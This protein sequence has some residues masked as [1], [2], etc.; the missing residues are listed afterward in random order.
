[1][2]VP[3]LQEAWQDHRLVAG[4]SYLVENEEGSFMGTEEKVPSDKTIR[5]ASFMW[6]SEDHPV[7]GW[8]TEE[9]RESVKDVYR[10]CRDDDVWRQMNEFLLKVRHAREADTQSSEVE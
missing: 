10:T 3:S 5:D 7:E 8:L 2:L 6:R 1:M 9:E 4:M